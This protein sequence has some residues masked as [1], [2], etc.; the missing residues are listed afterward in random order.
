MSWNNIPEIRLNE[1]NDHLKEDLYIEL[2]DEITH[3]IL[4]DGDTL[5][6]ELFL[7]ENFI[8][9]YSNNSGQIW[10]RSIHP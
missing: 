3:I 8:L 7:K 4:E 1:L 6:E 5:G 9:V 10:K 2:D